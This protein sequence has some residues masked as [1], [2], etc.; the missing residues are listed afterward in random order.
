MANDNNIKKRFNFL[1][2]DGIQS[3]APQDTY[4]DAYT[5]ASLQ[6]AV[7][8]KFISS[9]FANK[10]STTLPD[11]YNL[12]GSL[13][14]EERNIHI[15]FGLRAGTGEIGIF[16]ERTNDYRKILD[17]GDLDYPLGLNPDIWT[18]IFP[19]VH[20]NCNRIKLHF[21]TNKLYR[22][23]DITDP[24]CDEWKND[25]DEPDTLLFKPKCFPPAIITVD[26]GGGRL[27]NG[28]YQVALQLKD[29]D[30]NRTNYNQFSELKVV[31]EK[32]FLPGQETN[33]S[34]NIRV[35]GLPYEYTIGD[36]VILEHV[37][38]KVRVKVI[39][40]VGAGNGD[41]FYTYTGSEGYYADENKVAEVLAEIKHNYMGDGMGVH[42]RRLILF[43]TVMDRNWNLQKYVNQWEVKYK[44]WV[45]PT[46]DAHKHLSL[47]PNENY[48]PAVRFNLTDNRH[49]IWFPMV[50]KNKSGDEMVNHPCFNCQVPRWSISDTSRRTNLFFET[51]LELATA[52]SQE[53]AKL[54]D[55]ISGLNEPHLN[56][57]KDNLAFRSSDDP[58][59]SEEGGGG[60]NICD[61]MDCALEHY[62]KKQNVFVRAYNAVVNAINNVA[63]ALGFEP[64]LLGDP[65]EP[66]P[67]TKDC[68]CEYAKDIE[69]EAGDDAEKLVNI[70]DHGKAPREREYKKL[71]TN[72]ECEPFQEGEVAVIGG[73]YCE[74]KDGYWHY[75]NNGIAAQPQRKQSSGGTLLKNILPK[76][77]SLKSFS[78]TGSPI[79][80]LNNSEEDCVPRFTPIPYSEGYFGYAENSYSYPDLIGK[81]DC[82]PIFGDYAGKKETMFRVASLAKEPHFFSDNHG[83][84]SKYEVAEEL[85]DGS[86]SIVTGFAFEN[87]VIP[88][89]LKPHLCKEDPATFGYAIRDESNKTVIATG[90]L[91][92]TFK[93]KGLSEEMLAAKH[94]VNSLEYV[95]AYNNGEDDNIR[96][97]SSNQSIPAYWFLS[98]DV[99]L[100]GNKMKADYFFIEQDNYGYGHRHECYARGLDPASMFKPRYNNAGTTQSIS[101]SNCVP[102]GEPLFRCVRDM[103]YVAADSIA[104]KNHN[105]SLKLSNLK[106]ESGT[107]V[108]FEGGKIGLDYEEPATVGSLDRTG[109][110]EDDRSFVGDLIDQNSLIGRSQCRIGTAMRSL[111]NQ[112]GSCISRPYIPCGIE[113]TWGD[114]I[115]KKAEGI[116]GDSYVGAFNVRRTAHITD[117]VPEHL[118]KNFV[119]DDIVIEPDDDGRLF[120]RLIRRAT[121]F[122]LNKIVFPILNGFFSAI[123]VQFCG[124]P[125]VDGD[126]TDMRNFFSLREGMR[127]LTSLDGAI[128]DPSPP[129]FAF[130]TPQALKTSLTTITVSD[131]NLNLRAS[132]LFKGINPVTNE[133]GIAEIYGGKL[134]NVPLSAGFPE[135]GNWFYTWLNRIYVG[136]NEA[137]R[138][139]MVLRSAILFSFVYIVGGSMIYRGLEDVGLGASVIGGGGFGTQSIG[140]AVSIAWGILQMSIGIGWIVFWA[141]DDRD[142]R[143]VTEMVGIDWC[144]PDKTFNKERRLGVTLA[145]GMNRG[146][147]VGFEDNFYSYNPDFNKRNDVE[148]SLGM[149]ITYDTEYCPDAYGNRLVA[150]APQNPESEINAWR[151]FRP[152]N[153]I[154]I[155]RSRG[156][157]TNVVSRSSRLYIHTTESLFSV[158]VRDNTSRATNEDVI[159]GRANFF[160][161]YQDI[162]GEVIE[163]YGGNKD[164][165]AS[166]NLAIAYFWVDRD[167]KRL[168]RL[169]SSM[170]PVPFTGL[171]NFF[172]IHLGFEML[173]VNPAYPFVDQKSSNSIGYDITIDYGRDKLYLYKKD[174][175]L[176]P[177]VNPDGGQN[178]NNLEL[179]QDNSFLVSFNLKDNTFESFHYWRPQAFLINRFCFYSYKPG[180]IWDH[181]VRDKFANYYDKNVSRYVE[182]SIPIKRESLDISRLKSIRVVG[183]S[184]DHS[185]VY[186]RELKNEKLFDKIMVYNGKMN[187][188]W[189]VLE[190]TGDNQ[191]GN[192]ASHETELHKWI[193]KGNGFKID[194]LQNKIITDD[195]VMTEYNNDLL[196]YDNKDLNPRVMSSDFDGDM[197][198]FVGDYFVVRLLAD[199]PSHIQTIV[200]D[201]MLKVQKI[202]L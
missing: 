141:N 173:R 192:D 111:P 169:D 5:M 13:A 99:H 88:E 30:L 6:S 79:D 154:N 128:A 109:D 59:T 63:V 115:S 69:N 168:F 185:G 148:M 21:S 134:K 75:I 143:L 126:A 9:D 7:D 84:S 96:V 146:R 72:K 135:G 31:A 193:I 121:R 60:E 114:L 33:A 164:P 163:G 1:W 83:V 200:R 81:D 68:T 116:A 201:I 4:W 140:A 43:D 12:R 48:I 91:H 41:L 38:G 47:R 73:A 15:L 101:L 113:A 16:D 53:E 24:C 80:P 89:E 179:Y 131:A 189:M 61:A 182:V 45:V 194:Y 152:N 36:L 8:Q 196:I 90:S 85:I 70:I 145:C 176:R 77:E 186:P 87:L 167:A 153:F 202:D 58:A 78:L 174:F 97:G 65:I 105:F 133:M 117:H 82:Q 10:L 37:R 71:K 171:D 127:G 25:P 183:E 149:P 195:E 136:M 197:E 14:I 39:E 119:Y 161:R 129:R 22:V 64:G 67:Y 120:R 106:R 55:Y 124:I 180:G 20:G 181:F 172:D 110:E 27:E 187:S 144:Y 51:P 175:K 57:K 44:R 54:K 130:Y 95:D 107:Y 191:E 86:Y 147:L 26:S 18:N 49:T 104:G 156:A 142:N 28:S 94:A 34:L 190:P 188:G 92:S 162:S 56:H 112:Y 122:L 132:G 198:E 42:E 177:D 40:N 123:S 62:N 137:E 108:E 66:D 76:N 151:N 3:E 100:R 2:Q 52:I 158:Y 166:K 19:N 11:Q 98:A 125:P 138:I 157:V 199:K 170:K 178:L 17:D 29:E 46:K 139:K 155:P 160:G 23:V 184:I 103:Q 74:C 50:N 159:L 32:D 150:S 93:I 102:L 35:S 165:N 118:A